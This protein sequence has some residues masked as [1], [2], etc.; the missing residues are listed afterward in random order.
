MAGLRPAAMGQGAD[1]KTTSSVDHRLPRVNRGKVA[2]Q[3]RGIA[4]AVVSARS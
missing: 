1:P 2:S 3:V 4:V